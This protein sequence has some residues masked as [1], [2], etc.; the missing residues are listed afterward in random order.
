MGNLEDF[1]ELQNLTLAEIK[2]VWAAPLRQE[3][4]IPFNWK[5]ILE[6]S[7][8]RVNVKFSGELLSI[9]E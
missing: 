2:L 1:G 4:S 3:K 8:T 7:I 6:Y 5:L 9:P